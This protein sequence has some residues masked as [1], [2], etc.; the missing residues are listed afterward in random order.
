MAYFTQ[1]IKRK[2]RIPAYMRQPLFSCK[3]ELPPELLFYEPSILNTP[4]V[5]LI[6]KV[7]N[8]IFNCPHILDGLHLEDDVEAHFIHRAYAYCRHR[9]FCFDIV[10]NAEGFIL[11]FYHKEIPG[12]IQTFMGAFNSEGISPEY[13]RSFAEK[14]FNFKKIIALRKGKEE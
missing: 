14:I 13:I 3:R 12:K 11:E 5:K 8:E 4:L 6:H 7:Q 9:L 1:P 10:A 2:P